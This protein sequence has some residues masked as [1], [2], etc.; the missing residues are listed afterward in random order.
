MLTILNSRFYSRYPITFAILILKYTRIFVW[1]SAL[2]QCFKGKTTH[3]LSNVCS[4]RFGYQRRTVKK[5]SLMNLYIIRI[6]LSQKQ[7]LRRVAQGMGIQVNR[8]HTSR[9]DV[10]SN[11]RMH[12]VNFYKKI[13]KIF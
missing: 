9:L 11:N 3:D 12:Q 2:S 13:H 1:S 4:R 8:V 7:N 5:K 6:N 10:M